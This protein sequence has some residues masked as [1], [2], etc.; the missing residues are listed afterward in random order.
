MGTLVGKDQFG[1]E[2][3]ENKEDQAGKFPFE[4][5]GEKQGNTIRFLWGGL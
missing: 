2:Y 1:N 3:Y 4:I 5:S